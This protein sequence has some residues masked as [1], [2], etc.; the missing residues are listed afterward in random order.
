MRQ[1][2]ESANQYDV[3]EYAI[4]ETP[5][6]FLNLARWPRRDSVHVPVNFCEWFDWSELF[7][8]GAEKKII[9]IS[10]RFNS[11][12]VLVACLQTDSS[13][14]V[15][16]TFKAVVF[17]AKDDLQFYFKAIWDQRSMSP[18][19]PLAAAA[20]IVMVWDNTEKWIIVNDRYYEIGIFA[21]FANGGYDPNVRV[22]N[23]LDDRELSTRFSRI[24]GINKVSALSEVRRWAKSPQLAARTGPKT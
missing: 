19:A 5:A 9:S 24:L 11:S 21:V 10:R 2:P 16:T 6:R 14:E 22:F 13:R 12:N 23:C 20:R 3:V 8:K 18:P 17:D 7:A 1:S 4:G 15:M